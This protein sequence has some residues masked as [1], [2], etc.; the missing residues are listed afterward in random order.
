MIGR[1]AVPRT[2]EYS[3][4]YRIEGDSGLREAIDA[5]NQ[6]RHPSGPLRFAT[7][8]WDYLA[9]DALIGS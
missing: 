1:D 7:A 6:N 9:I 3:I 4:G 5:E 8:V 2:W